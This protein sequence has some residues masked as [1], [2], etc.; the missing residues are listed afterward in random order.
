MELLLLLILIIL[1]LF[2]LYN[3]GL[4]KF[5]KIVKINHVNYIYLSIHI[6]LGVLLV[7]N[8]SDLLNSPN[9]PISISKTIDDKIVNKF[10]SN[11]SNWK[12]IVCSA[13]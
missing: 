5:K 13:K 9:K 10:L 11:K 1:I 4:N 2:K 7:A 6:L 3:I 8:K 12:Y